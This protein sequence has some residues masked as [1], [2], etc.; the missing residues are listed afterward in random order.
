MK[1]AWRREEWKEAHDEWVVH[2]AAK[3]EAERAIW[4]FRDEKK[5]AFQIN[6]VLPAT[7]FGPLLSPADVTSTG[8]LVKFIYDGNM[9][10]V[11]W[12]PP[13]EFSPPFDD[14]LTLM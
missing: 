11:K 5:P 10:G 6:T 3:T 13:R 2:A 7:N 14:S 1:T 4:N 8:A 9:D 12:V